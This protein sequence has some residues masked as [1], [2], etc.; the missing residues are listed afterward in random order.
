MRNDI[1]LLCIS[2]LICLQHAGGVDSAEI[3]PHYDGEDAFEDTG[4]DIFQGKAAGQPGSS[5]QPSLLE[6]FKDPMAVFKA[7]PFDVSA[8]SD[9]NKVHV[10]YCSS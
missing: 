6:F 9:D 3:D 8:L 2:F 1:A 10:A 4:E 7:D 5:P